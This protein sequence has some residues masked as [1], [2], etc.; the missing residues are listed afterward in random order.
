MAI[1]NC[2]VFKGENERAQ[3]QIKSKQIHNDY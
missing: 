1:M 2:D 3:N